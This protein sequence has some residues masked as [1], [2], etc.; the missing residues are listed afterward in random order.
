MNNGNQEGPYKCWVGSKAPQMCQDTNA[1][2]KKNKYTPLCGCYYLCQSCVNIFFARMNQPFNFTRLFFFQLQGPDGVVICD[3]CKFEA[4]KEMFIPLAAPEDEDYDR[5]TTRVNK[6]YNH[7]RNQIDGLDNYNLLQETR[8]EI[9]YKLFAKVDLKDT[10]AVLAKF[11]LTNRASIFKNSAEQFD[12][13]NAY[14][15]E[16]FKRVSKIK[17]HKERLVDRYY[18]SYIDEKSFAAETQALVAETSATPVQ[19][20][21][22]TEIKDAR[23]Y[24]YTPNSNQAQQQQ[25]QLTLYPKPVLS[26]E[27]RKKEQERV[28]KAMTKEDRNASKEAGGWTTNMLVARCKENAFK[29]L[30]Q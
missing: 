13:K 22:A 11:E 23:S 20:L 24:T 18:R 28:A 21:F 26:E 4:T 2:N 14:I 5:A 12:N 27:A 16:E 19:N 1:K 17:I 25:G 29:C 30:F 10:E 3:Y 8:L 9:A 7:P 6:I 15:L